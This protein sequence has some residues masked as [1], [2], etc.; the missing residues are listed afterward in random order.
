MLCATTLRG[1]D[2][3]AVESRR[4]PPPALPLARLPLLCCDA[5]ASRC[6]AWVWLA[7]RTCPT[8]LPLATNCA[9]APPTTASLPPG[10]GGA[11]RPPLPPLA[12]P[13]LGIAIAI[14]IA[15]GVAVDV[16]TT[17]VA[18]AAGPDARCMTAA[19]LLLP[20]IGRRTRLPPRP[21]PRPRSGVLCRRLCRRDRK[22]AGREVVAVAVVVVGGSGM[23]SWWRMV[24]PGGP[25]SPPGTSACSSTW[26]CPWYT[27]L[28]Y[29]CRGERAEAATPC[30]CQAKQGKNKKDTTAPS[31]W[32]WGGE[33]PCMLRG[34]RTTNQCTCTC[35]R[36]LR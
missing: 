18:A 5:W 26:L 25:R 19:W 1:E 31:G 8:P 35:V 30:V 28:R 32:G 10:C 6:C 20:V 14:A 21:P 3:N 23:R 36:T 7:P 13:A 12:P 15:V 29:G 4:P 17:V 2:G 22:R 16:A 34:R 27:I 33:W 11:S 9:A 24:V